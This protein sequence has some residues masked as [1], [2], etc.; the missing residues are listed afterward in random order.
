MTGM[1]PDRVVVITDFASIRGGASKLALLEA[2]LLARR[3]VPVTVF[4]GDT[5]TEMP[6]GVE[7]M[8]LGGKR[9][10]EQGKLAAAVGGLW[11]AAAGKALKGWIAANDTPRTI[12]H[13]H[14]IQQTLSPAVLAPLQGL[15]E[16][17][18]MHAHDFFLSCPSGSFFDYRVGKTCPLTAMSRACILHNCDKRSY[19]QK[20]WRVTRQ[21]LQNHQTNRLFQSATTVLLHEDMR[22]LLGAAKPLG[23]V[24]VVRNPA[25]P[26]LD[27]PVDASANREFLYV[28]DIHPF[29][30]VQMLA[31]AARIAGQPLRF[32]GTGQD[33]ERLARDFPEHTFDGWVDR[34]QLAERLAE[35]RILV[36]PS[37]GPESFGLAP[38]EA[39]LAGVPVLMSDS[40]VLSGDIQRSGAGQLFPAGNTEALAEAMR[41]L[42]D[43][44]D[45]VRQMSRKSV[46]AA[47]DICTTPEGWSAA[48]LEIFEEILG[49]E[50]IKA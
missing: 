22:P 1:T 41:A 17:V 23:H 10:L 43:D 21:G 11:N 35:A 14:G 8:A 6:D 20:L 49:R 44:D 45:R 37:R 2:A 34:S 36:A 26:L 25:E 38:V 27:T 47:Q 7:L 42:A 18:V 28:G 15:R 12:Y 46:A 9:L 16:R 24:R 40:M 19:A 39:M 32:V 33:H 50:P 4:A 29:K 30:G 31:D 5:A 3:G 48:L 13:V